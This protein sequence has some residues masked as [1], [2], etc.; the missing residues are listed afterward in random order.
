MGI[1]FETWTKFQNMNIFNTMNVIK[2]SEQN[3]KEV[4]II[5]IYVQFF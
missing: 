2:N 5:W 3:L 1:F 4:N